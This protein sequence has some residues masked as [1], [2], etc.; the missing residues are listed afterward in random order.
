MN[1]NDVYADDGDVYA[2]DGTAD[3]V[4]DADNVG[5]LDLE[6]RF[7]NSTNRMMGAQKEKP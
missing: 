7:Y 4:G 3:D 1:A 5:D 2:D 6:L